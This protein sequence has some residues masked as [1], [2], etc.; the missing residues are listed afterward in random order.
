MNEKHSAVLIAVIAAVTVLLRF[1]PFLI[2][3]GKRKVPKYILFLGEKLPFAVIGMLIIYCLRDVSFGA[4]SGWL[5]A[6]L[7][8]IVVAVLHIWKRNTLLSI[9]AGT[10]VYMILVQTVFA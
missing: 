5:A 1:L 6:I 4:V 3:G 9:I 2:F 10:L 8:V 7:S